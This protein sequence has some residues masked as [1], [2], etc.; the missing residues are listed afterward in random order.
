MTYSHTMTLFFYSTSLYCCWWWPLCIILYLYVLVLHWLV[1]SYCIHCKW[2]DR[3]HC[4]SHSTLHTSWLV[5]ILILILILILIF[6][7]RFLRIFPYWLCVWTPH[8]LFCCPLPDTSCNISTCFKHI[9]VIIHWRI[10][11]R[12][13]YWYLCVDNY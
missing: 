11:C 9:F 8:C 5:I 10:P 2:N 13:F 12:I 4:W 3:F 6:F 1:Y 7:D